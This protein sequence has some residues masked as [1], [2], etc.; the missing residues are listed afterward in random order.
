MAKKILQINFK[1][2]GTADEMLKAFLPAAQPIADL[3]GFKWKVWGWNDDAHEVAGE[4]LFE[5]DS[6]VEAYLGGPIVEQIKAHPAIS[7]ISAKVFD[8]LEEPTAI[9]R[10]PV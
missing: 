10:G 1:F 9:T 2:N 8:V 5:N 4:Y 6:S 7:E 3:P